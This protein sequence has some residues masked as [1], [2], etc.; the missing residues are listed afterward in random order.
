MNCFRFIVTFVAWMF[1]IL[2][3]E[4]MMP[5]KAFL[6]TETL[7]TFLTLK[8]LI[9]NCGN[10]TLT[11]RFIIIFCYYV[12]RLIAASFINIV[13]K[14][15]NFWPIRR[16]VTIESWLML[17]FRSSLSFWR[18]SNILM[19]WFKGNLSIRKKALSICFRE[20]SGIQIFCRF[21]ET[22]T[23]GRNYKF[24]CLYLSFF[25]C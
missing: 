2:M 1:Y 24:V 16:V 25:T 12:P 4:L 9:C 20:T 11:P 8:L 22:M 14:V 21:Q 19:S 13:D 5:M 7:I 15:I 23:E 6:K 17:S 3:T 10:Y 18:W